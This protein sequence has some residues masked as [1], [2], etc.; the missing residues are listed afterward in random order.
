VFLNNRYHDPSIG[1]F[2]SVDPLVGKTGQP[3]LYANGNPATM[4]DPNGLDP[5]W[6]YDN[7]RCNDDGYYKCATAKG[8][9][10][11]GQQVVVGP[12]DR[13]CDEGR[14]IQGCGSVV[15]A[16]EP[17]NLVGNCGDA[18]AITR[19]PCSLVA[20]RAALSGG[21]PNCGGIAYN[22][23]VNALGAWQQARRMP[24]APWMPP[25]TDA[26]RLW[27]DILTGWNQGADGG[28]V[29]VCG[30]IEG[31]HG[32]GAAGASQC[33]M[34]DTD[35]LAGLT[36]VG[37]GPSLGSPGLSGSLGITVSNADAEGLAG[38]GVCGNVSGGAV[39]GGAGALC[40]SIIYDDLTHDW[41]YRGKWSFYAGVSVTIPEASVGY[42]YTYTWVDR[43]F[44][45]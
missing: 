28:G 6:A 38:W 2:I 8:G 13:R 29:M 45:W 1:H 42:S 23:Y 7:D 33:A 17:C 35:G 43:W 14:F 5:K 44:G 24:V 41:S 16:G 11:A 3:Y 18:N 4:S 25:I 34:V 26:D 32:P 20:W 21:S 27:A 40:G 12:G 22:A 31:S 9:P 36:T 37:A 15:R 30:S 39:I 10:N 19:D